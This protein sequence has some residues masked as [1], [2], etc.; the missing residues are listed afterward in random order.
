MRPQQWIIRGLLASLAVVALTVSAARADGLTKDDLRNSS[1]DTSYTVGGQRVRAIVTLNGDS[2]SYDLIDGNGNVLATGKLSGV[3]YAM[4][5]PKRGTFFIQGTWELDG[6]SGGFTFT[7]S[8]NDPFRFT[9]SWTSGGR[10]GGE[11]NGKYLP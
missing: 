3:A 5:D 1:W 10:R 7:A 8:R 11:W 4:V 2:G 6:Q 9:G